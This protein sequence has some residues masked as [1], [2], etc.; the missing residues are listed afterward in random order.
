MSWKPRL[1]I[2]K[3]ATLVATVVVLA[4]TASSAEAGAPVAHKS[5]A[6]VNYRTAGKLKI[7]Q[8]MRIQFQCAITCNAV[9]SINLKGPGL[10]QPP[11]TG[12]GTIPAGAIA[13]STFKTYKAFRSVMKANPGRYKV[14][15]K[16][17]ATD[18]TTGATDTISHAFRLKR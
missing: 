4:F 10:H 7:Q 11:A 6:I 8:T 15:S 14:V 16:V 9:A 2:E 12:S 18:P 1:R 17:T 5:G 13:E 3:V